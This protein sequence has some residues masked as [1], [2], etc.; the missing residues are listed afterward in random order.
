MLKVVKKRTIQ[1]HNPR[2][3]SATDRQERIDGWRQDRMATGRALILGAG[4]LGNE[5]IKN[6]ALM[7]VGYLLVADFDQIE[8]SNLS[9]AVLFRKSD[10][11][12]RR[13]KTEVVARRAQAINVTPGAFVRPFYG[14]IVWDLGGGVFRR[15]DVVVGCLDNIEARMAA[16]ANCLLTGTPLVDGGILGLAGS[17]IAVAPPQTACWECTTGAAERAHAT[18][19]YDSCTRV[20]QRDMQAGRLPAVQIASAIIAGFQTQE[21]VKIIQG[22]P[23]GSGRMIQYDAAGRRT[24]LDVV[25]IARR[26]GCWCQHARTAEHIVE[27]PLQATKSTLGELLVALRQEGV[28]DPCI[29]LPGSFVTSRRCNGC[30]YSSQILQPAFRLDTQI[31]SCPACGAN[32]E[33]IDVQSIDRIG[34]HIL[35]SAPDGGPVLEQMMWLTLSTLGFPALAL[36]HYTDGPALDAP[37]GVAELSADAA[38][39]MGGD[40]YVRVRRTAPAVSPT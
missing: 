27:L 12:Q 36:I 40:A 15:V 25:T 9:R 35:S 3:S 34:H 16:N 23:W 11:R 18:E 13:A 10:A 1:R 30:G 26:P 21:A 6:L 17:V 24:D 20:M 29:T 32:R 19:R 5:V 28:V 38:E 33:Q 31:L 7:G 14:D 22:R 2:R 37:S 4:A 39:V 8:S